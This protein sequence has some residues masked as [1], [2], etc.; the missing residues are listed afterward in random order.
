VDE[1]WVVVV[2]SVS[3]KV[4]IVD[5]AAVEVLVRSTGSLLMVV[6]WLKAAVARTMKVSWWFSNWLV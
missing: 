2:L 3:S 4:T 1:A 6:R 5:G